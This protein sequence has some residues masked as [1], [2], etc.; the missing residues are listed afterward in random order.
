MR[1]FLQLLKIHNFPTRIKIVWTYLKQS[2]Q[3]NLL[4]QRLLLLINFFLNFMLERSQATRFSPQIDFKFKNSWK[5]ITFFGWQNIM[6]WTWERR[7]YELLRNKD[8]TALKIFMNVQIYWILWLKIRS[9][10]VNPI[11]WKIPNVIWHRNLIQ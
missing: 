1:T 5:L 10:I 9:N 8:K 11:G 6:S 4:S 3:T 2:Q 7:I